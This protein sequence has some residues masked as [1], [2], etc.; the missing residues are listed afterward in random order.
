[1]AG[2]RGGV[3]VGSAGVPEEGGGGLVLATLGGFSLLSWVGCC[4]G[5]VSPVPWG[6]VSPWE[7][8]G[9]LLCQCGP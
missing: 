8:S 2:E 5:A 1:M 6:G 4:L 3:V 9:Q 7:G